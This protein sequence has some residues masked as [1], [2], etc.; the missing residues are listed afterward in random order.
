M[1]EGYAEDLI[2][3]ASL[4]VRLGGRLMIEVADTK[5]FVNVDI[6]HRTRKEPLQAYAW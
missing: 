3:P 4:D 2:N 1:I 5:D 6:S